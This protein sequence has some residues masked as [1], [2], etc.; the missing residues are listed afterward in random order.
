MKK[1][2]QVVAFLAF[3][4]STLITTNAQSVSAS[5]FFK[6]QPIPDNNVC[7]SVTDTGEAKPITWG[8]D[9]AWLSE[10]NIRRGIQFMGKD[11]VNI[12][13][14]SF[15]PTAAINDSILGDDE[16]EE[17]NERL[18]IIDTFLGPIDIM[19][20]DDHPSVDSYF[21][22][23]PAHWAEL[24]YITTK[25]HEAH[26]HKVVSVA[27]FNEP[28]VTSTGQGD[29]EDFFDIAGELRNIPYFDSIRIS[30]GN[31]CN[32]DYAYEYYNTLKERLDEGNTHQLAGDFDNYTDFYDTVRANGHHA[33]NDEMHN[34]MEAMVGI[35]H[36]LQT[37]IWWGT[38]TYAR[39]EFVKASDGERLAYA[40]NEDNWTSAAVYRNPDGKIQAFSGG[41]ERQAYTT[42]YR[43]I[44]EDRDVYYDG[45]GPQRE[46]TLVHP[47]GTGYQK[48]QPNAERIVNITWGDD[49][50]PVID[51]TYL[52]VNRNSGMV[53]EVP[54][55]S[56]SNGTCLQQNTNSDET[57][58]QWVVEPVDSSIGEDFSYFSIKAVH[59]NQ[60]L[61]LY[62][63]SLEDGASIDVWTFNEGHN[64]QW[65][66]NYVEDGWFYIRSK[67]S[68]KCL[69]VIDSSTTSGANIIQNNLNGSKSQQ[70]RF[71][72]LDAIVEF[73][74][75]DAPTNLIATANAESIQLDW[76]ANNES[77]IAGYTIFRTS[78][79]GSSYNTIAR[80]I[81][82]TS[83]VDNSVTMGETYYYVINAVDKSLNKSEYSN[84]VLATATNDSAL[85][86]SF[87]FEENTLDSTINLNHGVTYGDISYFEDTKSSAIVLNGDNSFI[88]LPTNIANQEEISITS[89]VYW[90]GAYY[91]EYLFSFKNSQNKG[92]SLTANSN[93]YKLELAIDINDEEYLITAPTCLPFN[94]WSTVAVTIG[95]NGV[96]LY[97][98][99]S[100]V[101]DSSN[102]VISPSEIK[103]YLNYIGR[104]QT[105]ESLFNGY[106]DE[107]RIYNYVLS[108]KQI[109]V[110]FAEEETDTSS[111]SKVSKT[112]LNTENNISIWP[113]PVSDILN[114]SLTNKNTD[115][116]IIDVLNMKGCL[117]I[118]K[119]I[120]CFNNIQ[121][122]VSSLETGLY[123][124]KVNDSEKTYVE[125]FIVKK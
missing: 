47:G 41:S 87:S 17:L 88:Q 74:A 86:A 62:N 81:S 107:F 58:Q 85:V 69:D 37:G 3:I 122:D 35:D 72:P 55:G 23:N 6:A 28:D 119:K 48:N 120:N 109:K 114:I 26:G 71:L 31:T 91:S 19:L 34:V 38:A 18:A 32:V 118:S 83:F 115:P 21:Y 121:I 113:Q 39:G 99:D 68:A 90:M 100:L 54:N 84:E 1:C 7:F 105:E 80:N 12:I 9:L 97:L 14:S 40:F 89:R 111:I 92:I 20:N 29:L 102:I 43:F 22:G 46:Y 52:L 79:S 108:R 93:N 27:P 110:L 33:T 2:F 116:L 59:S 30:G 63:F 78:S 70:W 77:D 94:E 57:Y 49:I 104:D 50:Q 67:Y 42:T 45:Y 101:A 5:N 4:T 95:S 16:L 82:T 15:T 60:A 64:Q 123:I 61:D 112:S 117:V 36:G 103:P 76:T 66:L 24:I 25:I 13:R 73:E 11:H 125:N 65:Y 53:I 44:S 8:L 96:K 124:L 10:E 75:P 56:T 51:G 98:N 106:I